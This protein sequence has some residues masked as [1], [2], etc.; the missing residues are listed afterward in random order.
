M[1]LLC[2]KLFS[3]LLALT[4]L[5]NLAPAALAEGTQLKVELYGLYA[6]KDGSYQSVAVNGAF[7][8]YQNDQKVGAMNVTADGENIIALDSAASVRLAP[9]MG[10]FPADLPLN[11]YGYGVNITEG[12]L[13]IAPIAAYA[14][15]GLFTVD[16]GAQA[17]FQLMDAQGDI[18]LTFQTDANGFYALDVAIP[19]GAYT[20]RMTDSEGALWQDQSIEIAIYTGEDSVLKIAAPAVET[21]PVVEVTAAPA[22][23]EAPTATPVPTEAPT[24]TPEP[25][26][27]PTQAPAPTPATGV[28]VLNC[29]GEGIT[30][31]CTVMADDG[32]NVAKGTLSKDSNAVISGLQEGEYIVTLNLPENA[33]MTSLN[34]I[35]MVQRGVTQWKVSVTAGQES[36]YTIELTQTGNLVVP[37]ENITGAKVMVEGERESFE[38][39]ANAEGVYEKKNL[40]PDR[41]EIKVQLPAGRYNYEDYHQNWQ[42]TENEDGTCTISMFFGINGNSVT[43]LPLISR[44][45][46]GSASGKVVDRDGSAM[47]GVKVTVYDANSQI[48][49]TAETD[50]SGAWQ[51]EK[52]TYGEYIAQYSVDDRAIPASSFTLSDSNVDAKLSATAAAPAKVTVRAFIDDNNNGSAGRGEGFLKGVEVSLVD[53]NGAIADTGLTA[54]DG[55]VTL[56]APDG[57]YTLRVNAPE[58]YGFG[59][60]GG[61]LAYTESIMD[62]SASRT[63]ESAPV[64][65]TTEKKLEVGVGMMPMAVVRG[66]VWND[67]NADGVW[68]AE[69]PG[70]PG[71]RLTLKGGKDKALL[72]VTTDENGVYEF[73][74][75][76]K[77]NHELVCHVPDEYVF[78][79]KAKGDVEKISRMTTEADRAGQD[80]LSL[81]RGEVYDDHNIGMMEGVIIE[82]VC[83]LDDNYNGYFDE[84]E[85]PLPGVELRLARQSNNVMLQNVIS[86]ENGAYHFVGQRG[87]TFTIRAN[88]PKGYLFTT[89]AEGDEGNKFAP[90]GSKSERR[91]TDLTIEN[92]G[93]A[94][95]MLGAVKFGSIDGRVYFDKNFS[96]NWESGETVAQG[97]FVTLYDENGTKIATKKSDAKGLFSFDDLVPGVYYLGMDPE[98][99][100]AFTALGANNVMQ[101]QPDGSGMSRPITLTMGETVSDAGIGMIVPA[102]V[103]GNVFADDNDNGMHDEG[104]MGL[105]GALV[106]LMGENGEAYSIKVEANGEYRFNAV[107]P[108]RYYLQYELPGKGVFAAVVA[109]GNT[110]AGENGVGK[111]DWFS[112]NSGDSWDASLCGGVLLSDISGMVFADSNGSSVMDAGEDTVSGMVIELIP[113]R[114][115]LPTLAATTGADG[116]FAFSNLRPDTYTLRVTC[117]GEYVVSRMSGVE[118]P[119][120]SGLAQQEITFQL[121]MGTQWH[122]QML[123]CVIPA[124][125]TG[126]AWLDENYDGL[127]GADEAPANGEA[128][129][130]R[131]AESGETVFTVL[132][133]ENGVFTIEGIAPGEYELVYPMDEGNLLPKDG[134]CDF[135]KNGNV[136]TN[137]RVT[138]HQDEAKSGTTLCV[139]RTTEIA[140]TVWLEQ[141]SGVNPVKG[142]KLHLLDASGNPIAECTTG[143]DGKYAF[144]GLMPADYAVDVTIPAGYVLVDGNDPRLAEKGLVSFVEEAQGLFGK[145]A[146]ITLKM[147]KHRRDMDAGMV[148]PGRLGDKVWLDLNGNGLQDGDESGIPGVTIELMR[149]DRVVAT[150]VSDQYG[151]Y[152]FEELYPTEY[153]LRATWPSE[154]KP[155]VLR[156]EI[157]QISSVLQENGVSIPV[158]VESNKANYAADLGFVPVEEGERPAGYGEGETQKWKKR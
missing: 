146:V 67:L 120:Q 75:V 72:E 109:G 45:I 63:Q 47:R 87:S 147:A 25:T 111:G 123:G 10:S 26:M 35:A 89:T 91:L 145:S 99:G 101:T 153:T 54:K 20:L 3:G 37:F 76:M 155:T 62:E 17:S 117:P 149:G 55:Y 92:G 94:K 49:A 36:I 41:Y 139:A 141:Y 125:W 2:K 122:E 73:H 113:A 22:P 114:G 27:A 43:E 142:A 39:T 46:T 110:I 85:K 29:A 9:V 12:R 126:E 32:A 23:T 19:A 53:E 6:T 108:G 81:E 52:L 8:V 31:A 4:M 138:I 77:G 116:K 136:M 48:A 56:S 118:M 140:G 97:S 131:D 71:V 127:R 24:A 93:Y 154:V 86:D 1:R 68:Q 143:E 104:E 150:T 135:I 105:A 115:D 13:N 60:K 137:G 134:S 51:V 58:D 119:V 7:D 148:L 129:E 11:E 98:K 42:M 38:V 70:I 5:L 18:A 103:S 16:A 152:V 88:L 74:Q 96:S 79:V 50:K 65:L 57:K 107:L 102:I 84:G 124:R 34:G 151:Y 61:K 59:K 158:M 128:L 144:K 44:N 14:K 30:V 112:V 90:N 40:L 15:A 21:A 78:T 33:V 83:F 82:G 121:K 66:T 95:I 106:R 69:E 133:D 157:H 80:D 130:L 28:L 64:T 100:Y 156:T 132:T